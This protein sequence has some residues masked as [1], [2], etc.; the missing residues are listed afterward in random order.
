MKFKTGD[1]FRVI[2]N[3]LLGEIMGISFN[4]IYQCEEYIVQ[5]AH[6]PGKHETYPV[7]ECDLI[8]E[9]EPCP[10]VN[11]YVKLNKPVD[12]I[13]FKGIPTWVGENKNCNHEWVDVGFHHSKIVCKHCPEVKHEC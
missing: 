7:D 3:G 11:V 12:F 5:W 4:S 8:W 10:V 13:E 1:N 6:T 9:L 2:E